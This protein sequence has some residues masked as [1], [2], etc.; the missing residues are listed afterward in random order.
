MIVYYIDGEKFITDGG[1]IPFYEISSP[2]DQM[3]AY[4]N[5]LTGFKL[6]RGKDYRLHRLIGPAL[7]D[8]GGNKEFWLNDK[9]YEN[10]H[11]WLKEHHSNQDNAFQIEM[12]LKYT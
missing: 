2:D 4:E 12:L 1:E 11:Y 3:P 9:L 10:I 5:L 8:T 6:W 7:I